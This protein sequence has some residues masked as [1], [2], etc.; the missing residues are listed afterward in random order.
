M[1]LRSLPSFNSKKTNPIEADK[2][3]NG[4]VPHIE[5]HYNFLTQSPFTEGFVKKVAKA[6][7]QVAEY[8]RLNRKNAGKIASGS[9]QAVSS[10][11]RN[12]SRRL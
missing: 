2:I 3:F 7:K 10:S 4:L 1:E 12:S 5:E 6:V 8:A 11:R 9:A